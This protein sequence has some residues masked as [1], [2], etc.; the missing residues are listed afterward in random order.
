M[1]LKTNTVVFERVP[2]PP[3][4]NL[5][6]SSFMRGG[7][8]V[9]VCSKELVAFKS[10]FSAY[11]MANLNGFGAGKLIFGGKPL[12]IDCDFYFPQER[13]YTK[14]GRLKRLDVSNRLKALHDCM[15]TAL[16]IDDC[17][18]MEISARK[19]V[20]KLGVRV[21]IGLV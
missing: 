10:Q 4:S 19:L 3:T 20:G 16:E 6:Y 14:D 7:R 1:E 15:A 21:E 9:R 8:V 13:L 5:A 18:F 12:F 17:Q 2:M 11:H